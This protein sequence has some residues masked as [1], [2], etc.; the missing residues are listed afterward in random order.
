MCNVYIVVLHV[1][2]LFIL[3]RGLRRGEERE[4]EREGMLYRFKNDREFK[5]K[6]QK[7]YYR[8]INTCI[9]NTTV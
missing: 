5:V 2:I 1:Y 7:C 9:C 3:H 6:E 4:K 8:V